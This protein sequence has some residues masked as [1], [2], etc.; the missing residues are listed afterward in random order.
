M[1]GVTDAEF[2]MRSHDAFDR[3][4]EQFDQALDESLGPAA[5][6]VLYEYVAGMD[7]PPGAVA[8]DVGCGEGEHAVELSRRFGL[9][10]TGIDPVVRCVEVARGQAQPL[11]SSR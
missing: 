1:G 11:F 3:I 9:Q 6:G 5:P 8:I 7:L 2:L 10:V 4:E